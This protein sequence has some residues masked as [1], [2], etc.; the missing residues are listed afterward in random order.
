MHYLSEAEKMIYFFFLVPTIYQSTDYILGEETSNKY[1][2]FKT[3]NK[4]WVGGHNLAVKVRFI[5]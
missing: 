2:S 3:L 1:I 4:Q 5:K